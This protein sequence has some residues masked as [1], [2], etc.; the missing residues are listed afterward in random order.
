MVLER[1]AAVVSDTSKQREREPPISWSGV[2]LV[3]LAPALG[4]FLYG[5]DIGAT[6]FVLHMLLKHSRS[7]DDNTAWWNSM[8]FRHCNWQQGLTVAAVSLGALAGSHVVLF[9]LA[10]AVGRRT[11][12]RIAAALYVAGAVLNVCSGTLLRSFG[13]LG[14]T[15][16]VLGRF[17]YGMGVGFVM[18]TYEQQ[19]LV[20][21]SVCLK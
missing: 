21:F 16:L 12:L 19:C 7:T 3:F 17:S 10:K 9:H 14:F 13:A 18:R 20:C 2:V 5:Y 4:G 6:S 1:P 11:E 15:S 8:D